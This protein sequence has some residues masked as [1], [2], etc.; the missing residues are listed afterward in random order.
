[1]MTDQSLKVG[2]CLVHCTQQYIKMRLIYWSTR[3][4]SVSS[5]QLFI[6]SLMLRNSRLISRT[7]SSFAHLITASCDVTGPGERDHHSTVRGGTIS[8]LNPDSVQTLFLKG[9]MTLV[10]SFHSNAENRI[11][12]HSVVKWPFADNNYSPWKTSNCGLLRHTFPWKGRSGLDMNLVG[13][14]DGSFDGLFNNHVILIGLCF[15]Q[16]IFSTMIIFPQ[17]WLQT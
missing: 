7:F 10:W 17:P 15:P 1:M 16:W 3:L 14:F 8:Q 11:C 5:S 13:S 12:F 9:T 2:F 4:S 6:S